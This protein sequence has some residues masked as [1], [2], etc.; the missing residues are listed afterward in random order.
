MSNTKSY[1]M[2]ALAVLL[3]AFS[4]VGCSGGGG[5]GGDG[6]GD[7]ISSGPRSGIFVDNAVEGL[8]YETSTQ[9]GITDVQGTF[10]YIEG[11]T[12]TFSI[13]A[14]NFYNPFYQNITGFFAIK[15]LF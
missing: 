2:I 13:G 11:E 5:G 3:I 14:S 12:I 6:E 8:Q 1:A 7:N 15:V 4:N 10:Q 9:S